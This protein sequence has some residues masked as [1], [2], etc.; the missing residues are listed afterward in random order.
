[1]IQLAYLSS[2]PVLLSADDIGQI[3]LSSRSNNAKLGVT[4]LLVYRDGNVLQFLE[5][6][7]DA[8]QALFEKICRDPRHRGVIILYEREVER[9][10]FP[11]WTMGFSDLAAEGATYLD[12]FEDVLG[13]TYDVS[14]LSSSGARKLIDVFKRGGH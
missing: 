9:R 7:R 6:E 13:P 10:D 14:K 8:V 1:M 11:E 5:G 4:G 2:T 3:L 12:G